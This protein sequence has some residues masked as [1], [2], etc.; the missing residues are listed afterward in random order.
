MTPKYGAREGE[1]SIKQTVV[2]LR[3]VK[4]NM[5]MYGKTLHCKLLSSRVI[6][7]IVL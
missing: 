2:V 3:N 6:D 7:N 4:K 5:Y 1:T